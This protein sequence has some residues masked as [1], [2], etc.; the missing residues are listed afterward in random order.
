MKI[1]LTLKKYCAELSKKHNITIAFARTPA[2]TTGQRFAVADL[3]DGQF[4]MAAASVIKGDVTYALDHLDEKDL[5][6]YYTNG[7]MVTPSAKVTM[8]EKIKIEEKFFPILDGGN[9]THI[10][11]N[12]AYPDPKGL[13]DLTF[14]ICR[15]TNL[16]YFAYSKDMSV[17]RGNFR[18]FSSLK[19][20][21][22]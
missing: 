19:S 12:E 20:S 22:L 1:V 21:N 14:N 4:R 15:S 16:G 6:I 11:L 3:R 17:C 2:E 5:P 9:I 13:M 10:W 18:K 7:T 8:M